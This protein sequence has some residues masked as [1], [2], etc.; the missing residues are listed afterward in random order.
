VASGLFRLSILPQTLYHFLRILELPICILIL[1]QLP[2]RITQFIFKVFVP[3]LQV[4]QPHLIVLQDMQLDR[5][6]PLLVIQLFV[7]V[8]LLLQLINLQILLLPQPHNLLRQLKRFFL[9]ES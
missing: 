9:L 1:K 7:L 2:P 3:L 5:S 4:L 6:L 8:D